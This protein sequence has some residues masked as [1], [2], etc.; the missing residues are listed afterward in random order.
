MNISVLFL[1]LKKKKKGNL[2]C[3]IYIYSSSVGLGPVISS[4]GDVW[5]LLRC[6]GMFLIIATSGGGSPQLLQ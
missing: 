5:Q 3:L 4:P 2:V 6:L 1:L